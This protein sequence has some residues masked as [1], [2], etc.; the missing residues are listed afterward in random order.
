MLY[1]REFAGTKLFS[2]YN[3]LDLEDI[4]R[5]EEELLDLALEDGPYDGI[6]G[7]S[8]GAQLAAQAIIRF[9]QNNPNASIHEQPFKFAVFFGGPTPNEIRE[10]Y[11]PLTPL[12]EI[13][14]QDKEFAMFMRMHKD[15]PM[16]KNLQING[17]N[18]MDQ[19]RKTMGTMGAKLAPEVAKQV[20]ATIWPAALPDGRRTLTDGKLSMYKMDAAVDGQVINKITTLHVRSLGDYVDFGE[21]TYNLCDPAYARQYFHEH[22]HDFPRGHTQMKEIAELIRATAEDARIR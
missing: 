12:L 20:G 16:L 22:K 3:N 13:D 14:T 21:G 4:V 6:I 5:T 15:N 19:L 9:Q 18:G 1:A 7:Y 2:Y 10:T 11:E 17:M 8:Q